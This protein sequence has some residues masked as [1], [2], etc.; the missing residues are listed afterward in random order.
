MTNLLAD[1]GAV[2]LSIVG[3]IGIIIFIAYLYLNEKKLKETYLPQKL[4]KTYKYAIYLSVIIFIIGIL[5]YVF[6]L[7]AGGIGVDIA[8]FGW[9]IISS[10]LVAVIY[11]SLGLYNITHGKQRN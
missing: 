9:I 6:G 8:Y 5:I 4:K 10:G 2:I 3:V 7:Y 11:S 1:L